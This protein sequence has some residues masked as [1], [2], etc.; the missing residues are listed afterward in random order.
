[1]LLAV[2]ISSYGCTR[3]VWRARKTSWVLSK[4]PKCNNIAAKNA[5]FSIN[6]KILVTRDTITNA[7]VY[8]LITNTPQWCGLSENSFCETAVKMFMFCLAKSRKLVFQRRR[9]SSYVNLI[10]IYEQW[11]VITASWE[12]LAAVVFVSNKFMSSC[13]ICL[14]IAREIF[15]LQSDCSAITK[16]CNSL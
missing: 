13:V 4:L 6:Y 16:V 9:L 5:C 7:S 3:E 11:L 10:F 2:R 14:V 15:L 1:M 12:D 8:W